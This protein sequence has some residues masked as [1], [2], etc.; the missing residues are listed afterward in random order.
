MRALGD[1]EK[2]GIEFPR[3]GFGVKLGCSPFFPIIETDED[4]TGVRRSLSVQDIEAGDSQTRPHT[5]GSGNHLF[6]FFKYRI[7]TLQRS[8]FRKL[9]GDI[10]VTFVL[11]WNKAPRQLLRQ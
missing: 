3:Q 8:P 7:G 5:L 9:H 6:D 2:L 4:Q 10:D 1:L 11:I